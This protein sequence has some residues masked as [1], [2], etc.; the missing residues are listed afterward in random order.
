MIF[1]STEP[2]F[3]LLLPPDVTIQVPQ[4]RTKYEPVH[5]SL[6]LPYFRHSMTTTWVAFC[7]TDPGLVQGILLA[8]SQVF[9]NLYYSAGNREYGNHFEQ[10]ALYH[11]GELLR[12]MA[13]S[14]PRDKRD[15]TDKVIAKGL[16]LAFNEVSLHTSPHSPKTYRK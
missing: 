12:L 11:R 3:A 6:H 9:A 16:F 14:M 10:R 15:V 7:L 8:S 13:D 5:N 4:W 2:A 1:P